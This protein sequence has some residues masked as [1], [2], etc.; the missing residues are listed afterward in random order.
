MKKRCII[1][2]KNINCISYK[3]GSAKCNKCIYQSRKEYLKKYLQS[4]KGKASRRR[5][6]LKKQEQ[7]KLEKIKKCYEKIKNQNEIINIHRNIFVNKPFL[8]VI[9]IYGNI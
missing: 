5:C 4:E 2:N 3:K 7:K 9:R 8:S 1:C 6:Y